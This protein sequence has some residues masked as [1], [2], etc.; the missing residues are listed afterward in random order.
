M[1]RH[2][3]Q[4]G[5]GEKLLLSFHG[6]PHRYFIAGD[7]YYCQCLATTRLLR[8][9]LGLRAEDVLLSFQSRVGR[10]RW[11]QPA[12]DATLRALPA[13]GVKRLDVICP[14]F[15]ADCLETLEEIALRG[16]ADFLG[17]G[18]ES[19][20]YIPALNAEPAQVSALADLLGTHLAGWPEAAGHD[21]SAY[22]ALQADARQRAAHDSNR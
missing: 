12:T 5:R 7:P 10:G 18:G 16:K 9:R 19:F 3:A 1:R 2:W 11:L 13:Q 8:E 15:A 17:A 4:H 6:I 22:A 20:H 14:G 21:A